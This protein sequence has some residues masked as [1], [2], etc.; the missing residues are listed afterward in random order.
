[1]GGKN[2]KHFDTQ[3][4]ELQKQ[5]FKQKHIKAQLLDLQ[6]Q[7]DSL[8]KRVEELAEERQLELE[9]VERL[10]RHNLSSFFYKITG[11]KT[12]KLDKERK[13]AY[14]AA[15]KYDAA[16]RE[17]ESIERYMKKCEMEL[18]EL[19]GCEQQYNDCLREKERFLKLEG[20]DAAK[21]ILNLE[22]KIEYTRHQE[23]EIKEA[24]QAGKKACATAER[25]LEFL[26]SARGWSTWDMLGGGMLADI[27][28]YQELD[29]VQ[30]L[31]EELQEELH[32]LKAE[33]ADVNVQ[34]D[35]QVKIDG[36]LRFADFFFD[37]IFADLAAREQIQL[38]LEQAQKTAGQ[39]KTVLARLQV[40]QSMLEKDRIRLKEELET[41]ILQG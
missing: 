19:T 29:Q 27:G 9:D 17:Q 21:H 25:I 35:I 11:K 15:V 28:K 37:G 7:L 33:L 30:E 6:E 12:E 1:M 26:S 41:C 13:E 39:L 18:A 40:M 20:G 10:E 24:V 3:L 8:R 31:V 22:K 32:E 5:V 36:F 34:A 2:M 38:S 23:K 4:C 16:V 14:A